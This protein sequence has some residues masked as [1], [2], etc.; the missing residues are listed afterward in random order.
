MIAR[1]QVRNT[2]AAASRWWRDS[3]SFSP[4]NSS[5]SITPGVRPK[6]ARYSSQIPAVPSA[7][8]TISGQREGSRPA[9]QTPALRQP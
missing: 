6:M 7:T 2:T 3:S 9:F 8:M 4:E 1:N 5:S